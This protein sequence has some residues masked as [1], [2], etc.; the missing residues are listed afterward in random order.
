MEKYCPR[1]FEEFDDS[2]TRCPDD[3]TTLLAALEENLVGQELDERY[4]I[5]SKL[6]QGGMGVVYVAEQAMIGRKVALKVLRMEMARDKA[7]VQRFLT[8]ARAI[9]ALK[10]AHTITLHDF[11]ITDKG[12]LYYTMELLEGRSLSQIIKKDGPITHDR[13]A[14]LILQVLESL[15]EA[16]ERDILHRDLKPDNIFITTDRGKEHATV[17][18]F[19]IAKLIGDQTMETI[20]Q[21]GMICGTPAY[22]S[23]EQ[24]LGNTAVPASDLYSLGIVL[25]EMLAGIPPFYE[26]TPMK[27]LLK[28]LNQRPEPI[29]V[30]NPNVE[31]P[32]SFDAFL[33]K[34]LEKE[35]GNRFQDVAA[36]RE[37]LEAALAMYEQSPE[38]V[39]LSG[40]ATS[41]DGLRA[42]TADYGR[43]APEGARQPLTDTRAQLPKQADDP[44]ATAM[45]FVPESS[46]EQPSVPSQPKAAEPHREEPSTGVAGPADDTRALVAASGLGKKPF[47]WRF[48]TPA[49]ALVFVLG[50]FAVWQPW[51]GSA[52]KQVAERGLEADADELSATPIPEPDSVPD[53]SPA[54]GISA[55]IPD[56]LSTD[57]SSS[58]TGMTDTS[59]NSG[60]SAPAN[61]GS[62]VSIADFGTR[63]QADV[64]SPVDM[65]QDST[66]GDLAGDAVRDVVAQDAASSKATAVSEKKEPKHKERSPARK[67]SSSKGSGKK[68]SAKKKSNDNDTP[69]P[70]SPES[71]ESAEKKSGAKRMGFRGVEEDPSAT[72]ETEEP[73]RPRMGFRPVEGE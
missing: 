44:A 31:V 18:D 61:D 55:P 11:G 63:L 17:L 26:T 50:F 57:S 45:Q 19:G 35:P 20:T 21:T 5:L 34:S 42:I 10:N 40:L 25:Y 51:L 9:S 38:T 66:K 53:N 46:T 47:P 29:K 36:F 58:S 1:C 68:T 70:P 65:R 33:Q 52:S 54:D 15:D 28:H 72:E 2:L 56:V 16:H 14:I 37:G 7:S 27:V 23:P 73:G 48:V 4:K 6:G 39:N 43:E 13:A 60:D 24:V 30:R 67:S 69:P 12:L 64:V 32:A 22:L 8:E 49:L 71:E 62:S 3:G 59:Q 41:K